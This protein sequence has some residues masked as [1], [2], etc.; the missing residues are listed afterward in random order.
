[1]KRLIWLAA[2]ALY[3]GGCDA[4][5]GP[6]DDRL[7]DLVANQARWDSL[8]PGSY[9]Y[10]VERLCF[11]GVEY[12][13]PVRVTVVDGSA[14]E[15]VYVDSG[16]DVPPAI[17]QAFPT[18]DGLFALLRSAIESDAAEIRVTYDPTLGVPLDFWI[19]YNQMIAD[20]E[21]GMLVTEAVTPAP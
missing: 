7:A 9:V 3:L 15:H 21:L 5:F 1:M 13:G 17:A 16:L 14:V 6:V 10:G 8:G 12:R 19:D 11:C 2:F 4:S 18:V 20:E